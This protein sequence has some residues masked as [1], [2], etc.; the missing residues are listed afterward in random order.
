MKQTEDIFAQSVI[1]KTSLVFLVIQSSLG[2]NKFGSHPQK[3]DI[4]REC[5][6]QI[7]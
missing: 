2:V 1:I 7:V 4:K 5:K 3:L 6:I